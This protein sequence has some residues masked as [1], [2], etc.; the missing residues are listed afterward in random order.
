MRHTCTRLSMDS[1]RHGPETYQDNF[2]PKYTIATMRW[3][4]RSLKEFAPLRKQDASLE[5]KLRHKSAQMRYVTW[6]FGYHMQTLIWT[7]FK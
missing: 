5:L 1:V 3:N 6:N 7:T 2:K 4:A